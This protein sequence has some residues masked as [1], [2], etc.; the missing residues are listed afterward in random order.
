L[1]RIAAEVLGQQT[2]AKRS[3]AVANA[4]IGIGLNDDVAFRIHT[5]RAI[6][7]IGRADPQPLVIDH[8]E[9]GVRVDT[10]TAGEAVDVGVTS[11]EAAVNVR[12]SQ[13]LHMP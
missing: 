6:A 13:R 1:R 12:A 9:L 7:Q 2:I 8:H 3:Y 11:E 5:H 4:G 10:S